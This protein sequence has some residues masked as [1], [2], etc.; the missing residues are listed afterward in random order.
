MR[1]P[2]T[3]DSPT[4]PTPNTATVWPGSIPA[5][6]IA[7]PIPVRT[8]Q[9][10]SAGAVERNI[11]V[12]AHDR[13]LVQQ[14]LFG[15]ARNADELA[16]RFAVLRQARRCAVGP[17]DDA[18]GAQ[19]RMAGQALRAGAAEP[20]Q[21]GDDMVAGPHAGHVVADR[22]DDAGAL[23]AEHDRPVGR[24][25]SDTIHDMQIAVAD[26]GRD[27]ADQHLAAPAACRY[28]P[29]RSSAA[30]AACGKRRLQSAS[31]P[32]RQKRGFAER[33]LASSRA[34]SAGKQGTLCFSD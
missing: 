9:P 8:P 17:R 18:A 19:I 31:E 13:I 25:A 14:H 6:R 5:L 1:A 32:P 10:I 2:W 23:V 22:L 11:R 27:G 3:I 20:G 21:A 24:E 16:K 28:R 30:R 34:G 7:A 33:E 29:L 15:I 26:P 12:D 4:P